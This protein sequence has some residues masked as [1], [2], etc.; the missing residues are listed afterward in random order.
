MEADEQED[1]LAQI[2]NIGCRKDALN[3]LVGA[4]R[5]EAPLDQAHLLMKVKVEEVTDSCTDDS[6]TG[7]QSNGCFN[8]AKAANLLRQIVCSVI[9]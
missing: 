4:K 6:V 1:L 2:A 7:N 3:A 8:V 9:T 5:L